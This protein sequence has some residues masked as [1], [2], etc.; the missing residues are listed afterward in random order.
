MKAGSISESVGAASS[1]SPTPIDAC[2]A[3]PV[4]TIAVWFFAAHL[5]LFVAIAAFN[6]TGPMLP[7]V[8]CAAVMVGPADCGLT[9]RS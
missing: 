1:P 9:S 2:S 5:P 3:D 8:L 6:N 7:G 4:N